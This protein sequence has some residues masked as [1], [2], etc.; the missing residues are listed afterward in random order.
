MVIRFNNFEFR[1]H[2]IALLVVLALLI[3]LIS[4]GVWQLSRAEQKRELE[5]LYMGSDQQSYLR[6]EQVEDRW[7]ELRYRE[8]RVSGRYETDKQILLDNQ[9]NRGRIGYHVF[10]PLKIGK[11]E[12]VLVNRGWVSA[13]EDRRKLPA[14]DIAPS[15]RKVV[16]LINH[17]PGVG[18]R[19]GSLDQAKHGFPLRIPY[20]DINWLEKRLNIKL[21]PYVL[22]LIP[23]EVDGYIR[24]WHP[25]VFPPE[26]NEAYAVTWFALAAALIILYMFS[27][28]RR[29]PRTE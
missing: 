21:K 26:R 6:A 16:G 19:I 23:G 18:V 2:F 14:I 17:P 3:F 22:L 9:V 5:K 25:V 13:D 10:T 27:T 28:I 29:T 4:L 20:L 1:T 8:L 12:W 11:H 24:Q 7:H 15:A